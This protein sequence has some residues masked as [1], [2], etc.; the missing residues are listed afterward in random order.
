MSASVCDFAFLKGVKVVVSPS[1]RRVRPV[2]L[3]A[4]RLVG[5]AGIPAGAVLDTDE[6][7][8][9]VTFERRGIM[10]TMVHPVHRPFKMPGW[11]VRVDGKAT[12]ITSSPCSA[13]T[14]IRC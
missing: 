6:L 7:N 1:S 12:R 14:R 13:S 8:K 4:M 10:Q 11:P 3:E 5:E 9:D 2:Q